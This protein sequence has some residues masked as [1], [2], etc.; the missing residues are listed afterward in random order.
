[1]RNITINKLSF[2]VVLLTI[3]GVQ[4]WCRISL[5]S[6]AIWWIIDILLLL[7][8][9]SLKPKKYNIGIISLYFVMLVASSVYGAA[10]QVENYWDWK[11]LISNMLVF[12]IPLAAYSFARPHI[13]SYTL[14][15]FIIASPFLCILLCVLC[16]CDAYGRLLAPYAFIIIFLRYF[17]KETA[18]FTFV[19]FA[20][21]FVLGF[22]SRSDLIKFFFALCLGC[23]MVFPITRKLLLSIVKPLQIFLF[24]M[25]L[26][27]LMLAAFGTF[28]V[29]NLGE[30]NGLNEKY[31]ISDSQFASGESSMFAD[32]RTF[33]YEEEI[34]SSINNKYYILGRSIARG[35]DSEYFGHQNDVDLNLNRGERGGSEVGIMNV[36]NYFGLIGVLLIALIYFIASYM[37]IYK[38]RN[39]F[40]PIVG[41]FLAFRWALL[42]IEDDQRFDMNNLFIWIIIGVCFSP[43]FRKMSDE[44]IG[45]W[46]RS[47]GIRRYRNNVTDKQ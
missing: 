41:I 12:S 18:I 19:A 47:F 37:A 22:S 43:W 13:L 11:Q 25:P 38:S 14:R 28:N 35:Y 31:M 27:L 20:I 9:F 24:F 8:L 2:L 45:H 39:Q 30:S 33:I 1:M 34:L 5:G 44:M 36:Y 17:D 46:T 3:Q 23:C 26:I 29:F 6:T 21:V 10:F 7:I 16:G 4:Q 15:T 32:T 40:V 42:W